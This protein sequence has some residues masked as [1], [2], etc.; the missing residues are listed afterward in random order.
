MDQNQEQ[1][2][3][4]CFACG[5]AH[6]MPRLEQ[7]PAFIPPGWLVHSLWMQDADSGILRTVSITTCESR[8]CLQRLLEQNP[9]ASDLWMT[10][11]AQA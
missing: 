2:T 9:K 8:L 6:R 7:A 10:P 4:K 11:T 1:M 5:K 3:F